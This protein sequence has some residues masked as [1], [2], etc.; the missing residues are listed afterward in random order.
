MEC[1]PS[2]KVLRISDLLS[3]AMSPCSPTAVA[4]GISLCRTA[5][6]KSSHW[7]HWIL[8]L[9]IVSAKSREPFLE[10]TKMT[11]GGLLEM[12]TILGRLN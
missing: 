6:G 10:L 8:T 11:T 4:A 3:W 9:L 5:W 12:E 2:R 7:K 1:L